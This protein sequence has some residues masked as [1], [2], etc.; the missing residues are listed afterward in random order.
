MA[1]STPKCIASPPQ[2]SA[3]NGRYGESPTPP[4]KTRPLPKIGLTSRALARFKPPPR[5]FPC[6][7]CATAERAF[8]GWI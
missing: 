1:N 2:T 5:A 4:A 6:G 7:K 8:E 3:H